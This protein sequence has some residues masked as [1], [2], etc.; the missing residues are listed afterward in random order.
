VYAD[1]TSTPFLRG[2]VM[3]VIRLGADRAVNVLYK[4]DPVRKINDFG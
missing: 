4:D 1:I 3:G 2:P